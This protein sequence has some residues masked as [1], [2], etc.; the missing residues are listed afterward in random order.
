MSYEEA[1][2][3]VESDGYGPYIVQNGGGRV[4]SVE[5][6]SFARNGGPNDWR[7]AHLL[8]ASPDLRKSVGQLLEL[9]NEVK[10]LNDI[11]LIDENMEM[12]KDAEKSIRKADHKT[13]AK[14]KK[15]SKAKGEPLA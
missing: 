5:C 8:S 11:G 7:I 15:P 9:L 6:E 12:L 3:L 1:K 14:R 4:A 2:W 10:R 13:T